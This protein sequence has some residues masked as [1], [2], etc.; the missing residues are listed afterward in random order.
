M[1][2][3]MDYYEAKHVVEKLLISL[4]EQQKKTIDKLIDISNHQKS[5]AEDDGN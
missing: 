1:K 4:Y 3:N 2:Q 5:M